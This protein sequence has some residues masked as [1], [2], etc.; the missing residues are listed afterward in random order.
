MRLSIAATALALCLSGCGTPAQQAAE[1]TILA[2]ALPCYAA[3][4]T[5]MQ[6]GSVPVQVLTGA[7]VL[8]LNPACASLDAASAQLIASALNTGATVVT[9]PAALPQAA[10]RKS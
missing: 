3:L 10:M 6:S 8:A 5:A 9:G 4:A 2:S 7:S 1:V